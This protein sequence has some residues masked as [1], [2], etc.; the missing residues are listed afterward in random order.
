VGP[1]QRIISSLGVGPAESSVPTESRDEAYARAAEGANAVDAVL[2]RFSSA[3]VRNSTAALVVQPR[4]RWSKGEAVRTGWLAARTSVVDVGT[5]EQLPDLL[6]ELAAA[7]ATIGGPQWELDTSN[8][9]YAEARQ[10]AAADARSRAE[11][12]AAELGLTL[13]AI[14]WVAEPGLRPGSP[15]EG[16]FAFRSLAAG[17][18]R[19]P[20][21]EPEIDVVPDEM[22][23]RS[24]VDVSFAIA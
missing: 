16:A 13:G 8:H 24:S 6:A 9:A 23:V 10:R 14:T 4:S 5:L 11:T 15:G 3:I 21:S 22:T 1:F 18:P 2:A 7:G 12:Y 20:M 17:A 19:G